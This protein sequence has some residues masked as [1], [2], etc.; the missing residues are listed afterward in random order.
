MDETPTLPGTHLVLDE[1]RRY[2]LNLAGN[3]DTW[4]TLE[5]EEWR[6]LRDQYDA[7]CIGC[8][9]IDEERAEYEK[10]PVREASMDLVFDSNE[11][12]TLESLQ[13]TLQELVI[14]YFTWDG[15]PENS[16]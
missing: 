5:V 8:D 6:R 13:D 4:S 7:S 3:C 15:N 12:I 14:N 16:E 2:R 9:E 11:I 1:E 10:R